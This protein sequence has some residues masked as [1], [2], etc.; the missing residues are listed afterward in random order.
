MKIKKWKERLL[1]M[2]IPDLQDDWCCI[3]IHQSEKKFQQFLEI[4]RESKCKPFFIK[5]KSLQRKYLQSSKI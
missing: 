3:D 5:I 1:L 2:K 4:Q